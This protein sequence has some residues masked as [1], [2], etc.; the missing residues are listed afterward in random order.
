MK[1]IQLRLTHFTI[2][3]ISSFYVSTDKKNT[4]L[5]QIWPNFHVKK[6]S[7]F[8]IVML[9]LS[10]NG[11]EGRGIL[12]RRKLNNLLTNERLQVDSNMNPIPT[13]V[14]GNQIFVR[15]NLNGKETRLTDQVPE[16]VSFDSELAVNVGLVGGKGASLARLANITNKRAQVCLTFSQLSNMRSLIRWILTFDI[17]ILIVLFICIYFSY[18]QIKLAI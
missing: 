12:L 1:C 6:Y 7:A 14:R 3:C 18:H 11:R 9:S 13:I 4:F 17:D 15:D 2:L 8:E 10:M 5:V 16:I